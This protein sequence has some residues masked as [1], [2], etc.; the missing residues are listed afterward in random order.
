[1][2]A[3]GPSLPSLLGAAPRSLASL[4]RTEELVVLACSELDWGAVDESYHHGP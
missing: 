3:A 2:V 1:M 4:L